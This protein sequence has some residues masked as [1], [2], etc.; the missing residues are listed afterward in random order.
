MMGNMVSAVFFRFPQM[1]RLLPS[2]TAYIVPLSSRKLTVHIA[3]VA[4]TKAKP[5]PASTEDGPEEKGGS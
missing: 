3:T 5:F 4:M 2:Q 1:T